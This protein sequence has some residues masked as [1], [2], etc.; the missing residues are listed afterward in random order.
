MEIAIKNT[1]LFNHQS[2]SNC[3]KTVFYKHFHNHYELYVFIAGKG[4]FTIGS[5][6]YKLKP[7]DMLLIRPAQY[8]FL[9]LTDTKYYERFL[10]WFDE[11]DVPEEIFSTFP[12]TVY[13]NL[14]SYP[15]LKNALCALI[16]TDIAEYSKEDLA[17]LFQA[18]INEFFIRFKNTNLLDGPSVSI[19]VNPILKKTM[20]YINDNIF[21]DLSAQ[22]IADDIFVSYSYL[23]HLFRENC[24]ISLMEYVRQKRI[25]MAK[26]LLKS[27]TKPTEVFEKCGFTN[28]STFYRNFR[29][30][31][32]SSP[33]END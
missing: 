3:N 23:S 24:K 20:Q 10:V 7:Y 29:K 12:D 15:K 8:H 32:N 9:T 5:D 30:Y 33:S 28:Y 4:Y 22:K 1:F 27:N 11:K 26:E 13:L 25:I 18:K 16:E 14:E 31:F 19:E 6:I 21:A 2:Y 17:C